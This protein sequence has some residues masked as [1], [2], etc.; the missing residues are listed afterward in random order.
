LI[1]H[2]EYIKL[3]DLNLSESEG[4]K[5][6]DI[7]I[8][9]QPARQLPSQYRTVPNFMKDQFDSF[10]VCSIDVNY[11]EEWLLETSNYEPIRKKTIK[12]RDPMELV[13][14]FL[15]DP[16]LMIVN[17]HEIKF[18]FSNIRDN[19]NNTCYG[20]LFTSEF[21]KDNEAHI[22]QAHISSANN[23]VLGQSQCGGY[24]K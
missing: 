20:D 3:Y 23:S 14:S 11:P 24:W 6:L 19:K 9:F 5:V 21:A 22:N 12:Y 7:L 13:A 17:K 18:Q 15:I 16:R 10:P 4:Q 8:F 2:I 1:K